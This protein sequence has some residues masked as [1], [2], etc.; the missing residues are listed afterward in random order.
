[1]I[2]QVVIRIYR[3][4]KNVNVITCV[5]RSQIDMNINKYK[6]GVNQFR[7]NLHCVS[8]FVHWEMSN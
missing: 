3:F 4:D 1:M 2:V 8:K 5:L 6:T 7:C